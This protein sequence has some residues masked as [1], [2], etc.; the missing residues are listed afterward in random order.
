MTKAKAI[1]FQNKLSKICE[2]SGVWF[3]TTHENRPRLGKIKIE[4]SI[5]VDSSIVTVGKLSDNYVKN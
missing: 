1:E 5:K 3:L 2:E 4:I